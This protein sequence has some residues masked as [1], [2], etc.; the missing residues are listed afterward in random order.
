MANDTINFH[1][2][3]C[4]IHLTVP[5]SMAG[6]SG[7]CPSCRN[8]IEA[9][10]QVAPPELSVPIHDSLPC[11][12]P[13]A[14]ESADPVVAIPGSLVAPPDVR[15]ELPDFPV[16]TKATPTIEEPTRL[17]PIFPPS[18][19]PKPTEPT[20]P[21]NE[22]AP[23]EAVVLT[24]SPIVKSIAEPIPEPVVEGPP[25]RRFPQ[26]SRPAWSTRLIRVLLPL[27][28][29]ILMAA[30]VFGILTF[31]SHRNNEVPAPE[32]VTLPAPLP[33]PPASTSQ[34]APGAATTPEQESSLGP[35][36]KIPAEAAKVALGQF[37]AAQ[38]LAERL[39]LLETKTTE[40]EM[41]KSCLAQ[42]LPEARNI[43][44]DS[45]ES[46]P[47][48]SFSDFFFHV[49]FSTAGNELNS[50]TVLIRQRGDDTP[51]I[52]ADPFLDSF[53][54]R[55]A[56][57]A[58]APTNQAELFQVIVLPVASC[59]DAAVPHSEKKFTLKLLPRKSGK[60]IASAYCGRQS[61]IGLTLENGVYDLKF[62]KAMACT[63]MLRWN[64]EENPDSPYIEAL[65]IK[66]LNWNP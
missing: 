6:V 60:E 23:R 24:P 15:A 29:F 50:Q 39:P 57:F 59:E 13:P 43:A 5:A 28:F 47:N 38:S 7:P 62:E 26:S 37:L 11:P 8:E 61:R 54:G 49:D 44:L 53:G 18:P 48:H 1:C 32:P 4:G 9:P 2:P 55:L 17:G 22:L 34:S 30:A 16:L 42:P 33:D 31:V 20:I 19:S 45:H 27:L 35:D 56:A 63:V 10:T 58:A 12:L 36:A 14:V 65:E 66:S 41:A 64:S 51:K 21:R 3:A 46:H 40:T 52:V 25:L